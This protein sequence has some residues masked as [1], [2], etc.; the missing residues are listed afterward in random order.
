MS[1]QILRDVPLEF[2]P[3]ARPRLGRVGKGSGGARL[4]PCRRFPAPSRDSSSGVRAGWENLSRLQYPTS[5]PK[6]PLPSPPR[7]GLRRGPDRSGLSPGWEASAK[8]WSGAEGPGP[9][10][11]SPGCLRQRWTRARWQRGRRP[12][13]SAQRPRLSRVSHLA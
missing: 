3:N 10:H 13:P 11:P 12:A 2:P 7:R 5:R 4:D 9:S 8:P 6:G 1:G